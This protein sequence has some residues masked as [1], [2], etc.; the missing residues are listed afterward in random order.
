MKNSDYAGIDYGMGQSNID[1][2]TGIRYGVIS[3][4]ELAEWIWDELEGYYPECCPHCGNELEENWD[5]EDAQTKAIESHHGGDCVSC[6]HNHG[7]KWNGIHE[8]VWDDKCHDCNCT[9][10]QWKEDELENS[11]CP[12]CG[13]E[14]EDGEQYA[15]EASGYTLTDSEIKG[16]TF[17]DNTGLFVFKSPYYTHA[18]F[19]SPCVPGAG[20]LSTYCSSGPKTYCLPKDYFQ[21][22]K[23]PYPYYSVADDTL[24]YSPVE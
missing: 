5:S 13:E 6:G 2:E 8:P 23:C 7:K 4:N 16:E 18:Q 3:L 21:D 1:H 15:D 24:I 12:N 11:I 22:E 9:D 10:P 17:Q 20:N 14:I 19:C